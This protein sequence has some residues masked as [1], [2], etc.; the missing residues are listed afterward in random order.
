MKSHRT[1]L[2]RP[3]PRR[4]G[5]S[6]QSPTVQVRSHVEQTVYAIGDVHGRQDLFE[7]LIDQIRTDAAKTEHVG[8]RPVVVLLGDLIDRGPQSAGCIERAMRLAEEDWCQI[9]SLKGNHEEAFELF[10]EDNTV[11]PNW[12][13]HGGGT[14]LTSYGVDI[15]KEAGGRGWTGLQ[16]AFQRAVPEAHRAYVKSMKLWVEFGDYLFVHAGVRPGVPIERQSPTDLLWIR[17]EFLAA[18]VPYP[19][20]VVVHGHTPMRQPD[21]RRWR[22]GIDTGAYASGILSAIRLRGFERTLIQTA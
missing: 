4:A 21:L 2:N 7:K 13:Q 18:E 5:P 12:M 11:G 14:T 8:G 16:A 17:Q 15:N 19:G 6:G 3:L 10:L 1:P 20:K 22:I 9:E